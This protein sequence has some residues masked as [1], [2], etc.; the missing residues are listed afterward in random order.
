MFEIKPDKT[1]QLISGKALQPF[2]E[3]GSSNSETNIVLSA[4]SLRGTFPFP[5]IFTHLWRSFEHHK[6]YR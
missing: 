4:C 3:K 5:S 1:C 6:I 2:L